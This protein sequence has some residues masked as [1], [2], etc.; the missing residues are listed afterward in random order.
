MKKEITLTPEG[1][2]TLEAELEELI[3]KEINSKIMNKPNLRV[4][5]K[6]KQFAIL[7]DSFTI[8]NG[9]LSMTQKIKRNKVFEKYKDLI[10]GMYK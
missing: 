4:F 8:E 10:S 7:K 9:L 2:A 5:E 6:V 1:K 3:K